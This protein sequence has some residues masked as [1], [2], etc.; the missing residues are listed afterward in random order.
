MV[1]YTHTHALDIGL[2]TGMAERWAGLVVY[3]GVV[4]GAGPVRD[5]GRLLGEPIVCCNLVVTWNA[6]DSLLQYVFSQR[7]I[8]S[9]IGIVWLPFV[10]NVNGNSFPPFTFDTDGN[11][12]IPI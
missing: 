11:Q 10:S 6:R 2:R 5:R 3:D 9:Y 4:P 1:L 7:R 12:T 8:H